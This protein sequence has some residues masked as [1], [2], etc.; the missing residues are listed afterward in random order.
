M[1]CGAVMII[2]LVSLTTSCHCWSEG[3]Q[4]RIT[5]FVEST[6]LAKLSAVGRKRKYHKVNYA[7]KNNF[8]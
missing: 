1:T 8:G 3:L 4:W 7:I 2:V 5:C 6:F